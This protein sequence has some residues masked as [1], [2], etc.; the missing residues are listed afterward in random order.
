MSARGWGIAGAAAAAALLSTSGAQAA[1]LFQNG[2]FE[3]SVDHWVLSD[4]GDTFS[5]DAWNH[6]PWYDNSGAPDYHWDRV[7]GSI[8]VI[9]QPEEPDHAVEISQTFTVTRLSELSGWAAFI[10]RDY[11]SGDGDLDGDGV[12]DVPPGSYNDSAFVS[13]DGLDSPLFYSDISQVGNFGWTPWTQFHAFLEP[14]TYTIRIGVVN[15][16]DDFN[17]SQLL[18]D[19]IFVAGVPVP[20][21]AG[22]AM[23]IGGFFGLG[24]LARRRR[25]AA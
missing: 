3:Q 20:E 21:P 18:A 5:N 13:V 2:S 4:P 14:G 19:G 6:F 23:L 10:G 12:Q 17:P 16:T 15:G 22:W 7:D 11:I 8:M 9:L 24:A 25:A 1:Q